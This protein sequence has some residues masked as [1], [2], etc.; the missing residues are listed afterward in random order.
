MRNII[1]IMR[2]DL[3]GK[4]QRKFLTQLMDDPIIPIKMKFYRA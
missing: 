3:S 1:N 4:F 2:S